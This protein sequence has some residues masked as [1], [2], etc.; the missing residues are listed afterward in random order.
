[1]K[2]KPLLGNVKPKKLTP[3]EEEMRQRCIKDIHELYQKNK[4][5]RILGQRWGIR[6]ENK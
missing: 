6:K 2:R 1:M 4:R 3:E 5:Q